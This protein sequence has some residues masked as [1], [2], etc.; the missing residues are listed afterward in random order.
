MGHILCSLEEQREATVN[1]DAARQNGSHRE[2]ACEER[3]RE[4]EWEREWTKR[5]EWEHPTAPGS[6]VQEERRMKEK[7][8][9]SAARAI[10]VAYINSSLASIRSNRFHR[11]RWRQ[12][13][14]THTH[15]RRGDISSECATCFFAVVLLSCAARCVSIFMWSD[16]RVQ[17]MM[18]S[19]D[20]IIFDFVQLTLDSSKGSSCV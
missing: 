17:Q 7:K 15:R 11:L 19:I 5:V 16:H 3:G 20:A 8:T 4:R 2:R 12:Q 14:H 18:P 6:A 10:I 9:M 1:E 13:Q